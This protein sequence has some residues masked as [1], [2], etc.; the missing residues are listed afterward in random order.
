MPTAVRVAVLGDSLALSPTRELNVASELEL[1]AA[2]AH[3]PV[4]VSNFSGW[5]DTT[6]DGLRRLDSALAITPHILVVQLGAN[7]GLR[8]M[9]VDVVERNLDA[10][11]QRAQARRVG[12]L[13]CGMEAPPVHGFTYTLEFHR[14]FPRLATR[15]QVPLVP[16]VLA[17]VVF[18]PEFNGPDGLHP[19]AAG[20]RRM[21]ATIWPYLE[22]LIQQTALFAA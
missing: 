4:R 2:A 10:I 9:A 21:A 13:L 17:G 15:H 7:D 12:V 22:P 20:A 5:G 14:L 18:N 19:N 3:L 1:R 16:F 8:G 6:A 11:L